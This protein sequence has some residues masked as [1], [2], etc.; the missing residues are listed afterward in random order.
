MRADISGP[1]AARGALRGQ[2]ANQV[3]SQVAIRSGSDELRTFAIAAGLCWSVL[4]VT[5]GL[6]YDLQM[7]G[8]GSI[9]SYSVAV[10]DAWAFHWHNIAGRV[11][12]YL[13]SF[14]PAETYVALTGN[15]HGG[16]VV[17]GFLFFA[18]QLFGLAATLAADRS[19][20]RIVFSY[21]CFSTACLCPLV[22]GFPTE[23]WMA[24]ALFWP[25]LAV[26]H[27][28]DRG[29][30]GFALV[31]GA[32]LA[33]LFTH[34]GALVLT[35][36]IL[37]TLVLR[38]VRDAAFTR[39]A[40]VWLVAVPMWAAV[41]ALFPPDDYFGY[42]LYQSALHFFDVTI[43]TCDVMRLLAGALAGYGVAFL[44]ARRW[45]P[46]NA[47]LCAVAILTAALAAYWVW[48]DHTLHAESRYYMRTVLLVGTAGL[49]AL[50]AA[51]A[52]AAEGRLNLPVPFLPAL[53]DGLAR[54]MTARAA[55]GAILI[56][57][58]VHAVET[59]K[60]VTVWTDYKAA[61]RTLARGP[62][63]DPALGDRRFVST[64]RIGAD[65]GR[66]SWFSTTPFL[67]VLVAP[68]FAPSRLV[69][70]PDSDY[71]WLSCA[72][73][74]ENLEAVRAVPAAS[75]RLVRVYSCLHR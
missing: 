32:L 39:G 54:G 27:Y 15:A 28:A 26:C 48:F 63:S 75:R 47:H 50:A 25:T 5:I 65:L 24:H 7:Y 12:V 10:R 52:L 8:D 57:M 58:L 73:A 70:D 67:S 38:G 53:L 72:T 37:A 36:A 4:F 14:V 31:F 55:T 33:L 30:G 29:V 59:A 17:Y 44:V 6:R 45:T 46:A 41:H 66:M 18:A 1:S 40:S 19:P 60:F 9:F 68:K 20:G 42:A 13:F 43:L 62:A 51:Y 3:A 34:G 2:V 71:F 61:V 21:A 64:H 16:I 23:M 22:F 56:V 69:V 11:F 49:G 74:T 35:I